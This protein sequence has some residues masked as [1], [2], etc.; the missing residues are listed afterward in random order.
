MR[1]VAAGLV[2]ALAGCALEADGPRVARTDAAAHALLAPPASCEILVH[3][4]P[5]GV[6]TAETVRRSLEDVRVPVERALCAC[7]PR[8]GLVAPASLTASVTHHPGAGEI[9]RV[10]VDLR[11]GDFSHFDW[12]AY[13]SCV[14][15]SAR[16]AP[17]AAWPLGSCTDPS[18]TD[19]RIVLGA[20]PVAIR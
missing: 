2:S 6:L 18:S 15:A 1:L 14:D 7:G 11:D 10:T 5:G 17:L 13:E 12:Q 9:E 8:A 4:P 3:N 16:A 20:L 19:S